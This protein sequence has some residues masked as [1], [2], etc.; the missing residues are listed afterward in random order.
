MP[1]IPLPQRNAIL[2]S[3]G[4]RVNLP[5]GAQQALGSG[6]SKLG[7]TLSSVG[8]M[9]GDLA[10]RAQKSLVSQEISSGQLNYGE[11]MNPF[12]VDLANNPKYG[13]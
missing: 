7:Q 9:F 3:T 2:P 5:Y 10:V 6:F 13:E 4:G 8:G 12:L 11:Q 1:K